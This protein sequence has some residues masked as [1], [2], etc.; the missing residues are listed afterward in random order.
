[1]VERGR[2]RRKGGG[3][4]RGG[5]FSV[6]GVGACGRRWTAAKVIMAVM[7]ATAMGNEENGV[8]TAAGRVVGEASVYWRQGGMTHLAGSRCRSKEQSLT[9]CFSPCCCS[10]S[11]MSTQTCD[12]TNTRYPL[13]VTASLM[14]LDSTLQF[15]ISPTRSP[16]QRRVLHQGIL[17]PPQAIGQARDPH[18]GRHGQDRCPEGARPL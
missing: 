16:P 13:S 3:S 15:P 10:L 11:I 2:C 18:L 14:Q 8:G 5:R 6:G 17:V 12:L 9:R 1:L 4:W 7:A